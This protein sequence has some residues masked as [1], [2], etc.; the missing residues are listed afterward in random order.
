MRGPRTSPVKPEGSVSLCVLLFDYDGCGGFWIE[1]VACEVPGIGIWG[2]SPYHIKGE[3]NI[4][5]RGRRPVWKGMMT[6]LCIKLRMI[7]V[8]YNKVWYRR[9]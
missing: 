9:R 2:N 1:T 6:A 8:Y 4:P 5:S 7:R 3:G